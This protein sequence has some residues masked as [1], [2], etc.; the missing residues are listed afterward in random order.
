MPFL[1]L[2]SMALFAVKN[3]DY[4]FGRKCEILKGN[5][6]SYQKFVLPEMHKWD[7]ISE[8]QT[9]QNHTPTVVFFGDSRVRQLRDGLVHRLIGVDQ[10]WLA[11]RSIIYNETTYRKHSDRTMILTPDNV[12]YFQ[13]EFIWSGHINLV[14]KHLKRYVLRQR[15][16]KL[17]AKGAYRKPNLLIIGGSAW[18]YSAPQ[19]SNCTK[20]ERSKTGC[21]IEYQRLFE[22]LLAVL[23]KSG[24]N[25]PVLWV[26]QTIMDDPNVV[27]TG[28]SNANMRTYNEIVHDALRNLDR[29]PPITYW[30]SYEKAFNL[31]DSLDGMHLGPEA[32]R[33]LVPFLLNYLCTLLDNMQCYNNRGFAMPRPSLEFTKYHSTQNVK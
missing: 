10:D 33:K 21:G 15:Q 31:T 18:Q 9:Y 16:L 24:L 27:D 17:A 14:V 29:T 25:T 1:F 6:S 23:E 4:Q 7:C 5:R 20:E 28:V 32:K 13:M 12:T 22:K 30:E 26:P 19:F 2:W 3:I 11:N 8:L